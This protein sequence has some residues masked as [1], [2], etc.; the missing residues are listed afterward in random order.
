MRRSGGRAVR[1]GS[2]FPGRGQVEGRLRTSPS[3]EGTDQ[4]PQ[5]RGEEA[6][7]PGHF[8]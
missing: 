4:I 6:M 3:G 2:W 8:M 5:G 1:P 7:T